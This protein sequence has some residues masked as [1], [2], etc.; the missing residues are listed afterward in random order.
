VAATF[1]SVAD[2]TLDEVRV[3]LVYPEDAASDQ[4]FRDA[5]RL[6]TSDRL[7]AREEPSHAPLSGG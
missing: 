3:E 6:V 1:E 5:S 7:P 4:F 2:V